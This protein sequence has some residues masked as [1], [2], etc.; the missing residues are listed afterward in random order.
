M[1]TSAVL[2]GVWDDDLEMESSSDELA[3]FDF[4]EVCDGDIVTVGSLESVSDDD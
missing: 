2:D 1:D 4:S 3:V